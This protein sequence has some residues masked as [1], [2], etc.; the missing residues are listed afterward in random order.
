MKKRQNGFT[1]IELLTVMTVIGIL[2]AIAI[3]K[4]IQYRDQAADAAALADAANILKAFIA[5][6]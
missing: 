2:A 3:P 1:M 6:E 4:F 5:N